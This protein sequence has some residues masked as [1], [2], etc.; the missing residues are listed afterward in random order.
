MLTK[1]DVLAIGN[2][3]EQKIEPITKQLDTDAMKV[4]AVNTRTARIEQKPDREVTD[5]AEN[6][7]EIMT[8]L[9]KL[10]D[11]ETRIRQLEGSPAPRSH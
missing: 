5:L 3:V 6:T 4:E 1:D 11:H 9:D 10:D 8:K 2:L 7:K